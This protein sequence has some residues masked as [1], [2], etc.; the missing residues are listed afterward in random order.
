MVLV[1]ELRPENLF[2]V[3]RRLFGVLFPHQFTLL[4][5]RDHVVDHVLKRAGGHRVGDVEPVDLGNVDPALNLVG[6]FG[7]GTPEHGTNTTHSDLVGD[8]LTRL[9]DIGRLAGTQLGPVVN[10]TLDGVG[11][12][13]SQLFVFTELA[14]VDPGPPREKRLGPFEV[15]VRLV[16]LVLFLGL[17]VGGRDDNGDELQELDI[18]LSAV[19]SGHLLNLFDLSP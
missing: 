3:G 10:K 18:V 6:D 13:V 7:G 8:V 16:V 9:L 17:L 12:G 1:D 2:A 5:F 19:L 14:N 15:A 4:Q 11:A